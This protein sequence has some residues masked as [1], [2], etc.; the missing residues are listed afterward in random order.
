MTDET[1]WVDHGA[2][3]G[4]GDPEAANLMR[5][6]ATQLAK[7]TDERVV[8]AVGAAL[9]AD[10]E[11]GPTIIAMVETEAGSAVNE[12]LDTSKRI[13][14]DRSPT[15]IGAESENGARLWRVTSDG[16]MHHG[17][18]VITPSGRIQFRVGDHIVFD[19]NP[20]TLETIIPGYRPTGTGASASVPRLVLLVVAGQSNADGRGQP[21]GPELD[22]RDD[23]I[24]M[25]DWA[26][27]TIRT[28]TVPLSSSTPMT[29]AGLSPATVFAREIVANEPPGTVVLI[30]NTAVGGSGLIGDAATGNWGVSYAGANPR[31]YP[32]MLNAL[33]Q[34]IATATTSLRSPDEIRFLWH[35]GEADNTEAAYA[36]AFD[37]LV[38]GVRTHLGRPDMTVTLGGIVP[39]YIKASPNRANVR[40]A[41]I[42]AQS[43]LTRTGYADGIPNGGGSGS[44]T[45]IVH[46]SRGGVVALGKAMYE[47]WKRAVVNITTSTP[48]PP[49]SVRATVA[50]GQLRVTWSPAFCRVTAYVVEQSG[51]GVAWST[52]PAGSVPLDLTREAAAAGATPWVRV[53]TTNGAT[54]SAP[55]SPTQA[56]GA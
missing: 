17:N 51:D 31:L 49:L 52:I 9:K 48:V 29:G 4:L 50:G 54:T 55:S 6:N 16:N 11:L 25:W 24:L 21:I 5:N 35:Q 43:R 22:P 36:A 1:T 10:E 13:P 44:V 7:A 27:T 41:H 14:E 23:R 37:E 26:A 46:Y 56:I 34:A 8:P 30:V 32:R 3:A 20:D 40:A 45:D 2:L 15:A 19:V 28:A 42:G 12:V 53:S 39:E 38:A 47:A 18:M 33:D